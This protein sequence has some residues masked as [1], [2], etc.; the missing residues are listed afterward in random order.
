MKRY[1]LLLALLAFTG[2]VL[3]QAPQTVRLCSGNPCVP[4]SSTD[5]LPITGGG[6]GATLES[7]ITEVNSIAV[8]AG[9][10]PT[11]GGTL[12]VIQSNDT[13][14]MTT[15]GCTVGA[16]SAQ[17]LAAAAAVRWLQVQNNHATNDVACSWGGTAALNSNTSFMLKPGQTASYGPNTGG[18]PSQALNCIAGGAGTPLY[19]E[20]R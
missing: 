12:R 7:N 16:A 20:H 15:A 18:V 5:P 19:V 2:P 11:T 10:G 1:F 8:G 9:A 13:S 3:A 4:V 14:A 6:G 17:C